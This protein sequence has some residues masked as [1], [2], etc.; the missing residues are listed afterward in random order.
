MFHLAFGHQV[1]E[2]LHHGVY[3][4]GGGELPAEGLRHQA[5]AVVGGAEAEHNLPAFLGG[6]GHADARALQA[7]G[8]DG[9]GGEYVQRHALAGV[10]AVADGLERGGGVERVGKQGEAG[11]G[12]AFLPILHQGQGGLAE[13]AGGFGRVVAQGVHH[14]HALPGGDGDFCGVGLRSGKLFGSGAALFGGKPLLQLDAA[15]L[16]G[17]EQRGQP[18]GLRQ[19]AGGL[20][21]G[22]FGMK[23]GGIEGG[24]QGD[25]LVAAG[26]EY[27]GQGEP[28]GFFGSGGAQGLLHGLPQGAVNGIARRHGER[29]GEGGEVAR[30]QHLENQ[31]V[32][33]VAGEFVLRAGAVGGHGFG[34]QQQLVF[35]R[36]GGIGA[37][38]GEEMAVHNDDGKVTGWG[39]VATCA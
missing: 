1:E 33:R 28:A 38:V 22:Q 12:E 39:G 34:V 31:A 4:V 6:H 36:I 14:V 3:G 29:H 32:Q 18:H 13:F 26:H 17:G 25:G 19:M 2:V 30:L 21:F 10:A 5:V 37:G 27:H 35:H 11:P 7:H 24:G 9:V 16:L 15:D 20:E 23:R 8:A